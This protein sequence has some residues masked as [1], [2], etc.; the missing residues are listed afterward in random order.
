MSSKPGL[1]QKTP[2]PLSHSGQLL[3]SPPDWSPPPPCS[4]RLPS[5]CPPH[6]YLTQS[7]S[8][9]HSSDHVSPGSERLSHSWLFP[10]TFQLYHITPT[11]PSQTTWKS[12]CSLSKLCAYLYLPQCPEDSSSLSLPGEVLPSF[13]ASVQ[14]S[15]LVQFLHQLS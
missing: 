10:V 1:P 12:S 11:C 15:L 7:P 5:T 9:Q 3:K 2:K 13:R 8:L 6:R 14:M 4:L